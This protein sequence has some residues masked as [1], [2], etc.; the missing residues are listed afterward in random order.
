MLAHL[1]IILNK[2]K[3]FFAV[4][5]LN[6]EFL[7]KLIIIYL[8]LVF[9][10]VKIMGALSGLRCS[11]FYLYGRDLL[12]LLVWNVCCFT[13]FCTFLIIIFAIMVYFNM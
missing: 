13:S 3:C 2:I 5:M 11:K 8:F 9:K 7:A 10:Y 4:V 6:V 1:D 12:I